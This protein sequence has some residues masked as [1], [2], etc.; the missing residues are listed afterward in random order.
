MCCKCEAMFTNEQQS[1]V[2]FKIPRQ[3][4]GI[5]NLIKHLLGVYLMTSNSFLKK[6]VPVEFITNWHF[7]ESWTKAYEKNSMKLICKKIHVQ[8]SLA[9]ILFLQRSGHGI[10]LVGFRIDCSVKTELNCGK[11]N[12][13]QIFHK[14]LVSQSVTV[15]G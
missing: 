13:N 10:F 14:F 4:G 12:I 6:C 9:H 7:C 15:K 5:L 3:N 2:R 1:F 8:Y 11:I